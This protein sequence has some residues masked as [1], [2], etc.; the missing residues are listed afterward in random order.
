MSHDRPGGTLDSIDQYYSGKGFSSNP[1]LEIKEEGQVASYEKPLP[2]GRVHIR[3]F[4]TAKYYK[5][6]QHTDS[7]DPNRNPV[8]HLIDFIAPGE[9][10]EQRIRRRDAS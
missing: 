10:T 4:R 9:H 5:I 7:V 2:E 6:N 1:P 8:G 3:V